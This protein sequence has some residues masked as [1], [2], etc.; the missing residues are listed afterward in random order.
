MIPQEILA[1]LGWLA[2]DVFSPVVLALL[3]SGLVTI[4]VYKWHR[5]TKVMFRSRLG[6]LAK[7]FNWLVFCLAFIVFPY[8][9]LYEGRALL[10]LAVAFLMLSELAYQYPLFLY[11]ARGI[12]AWIQ[13]SQ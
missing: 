8:L 2:F 13:R 7:A 10:R 5:Y 12:K 4:H 3:A 9:P 6:Y 1:F 11:A